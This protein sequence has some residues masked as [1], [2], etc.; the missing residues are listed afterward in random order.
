MSS[1]VE[2]AAADVG[3]RL[4]APP[5]ASKGKDKK[6]AEAARE[7]AREAVAQVHAVP[8]VRGRAGQ[9]WRSRQL[10]QVPEIWE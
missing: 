3:L 7:A 8:G 6:A 2:R 4:S 5:L 10:K 1:G 9:G